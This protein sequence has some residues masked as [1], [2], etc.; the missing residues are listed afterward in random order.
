MSNF[1]LYIF[2]WNIIFNFIIYRIVIVLGKGIPMFLI[3]FL[4]LLFYVYS[5]FGASFDLVPWQYTFYYNIFIG[6][7]FTFFTFTYKRTN[8]R[9]KNVDSL[10]LK[11]NLFPLYFLL[12]VLF[13]TSYPL[14]DLKKLIIP[15]TL[16]LNKDIIYSVSPKSFG[17]DSI[18]VISG[19]LILILTPFYYLSLYG[20]RDKPFKLFLLLFFPI[21]IS[22]SF[23]GYVGRSTLVPYLFIYL[24]TL[25][26]F[27]PDLRRIM[28]VVVSV[29]MAPLIF[30]LYYYS[31][32]RLGHGYENVTFSDAITIISG[33]E[34]SFPRHY[35]D[36][37]NYSFDYKIIDYFIWLFTLPF[38]GFL[39]NN[40]VNLNVNF[41]FSSFILGIDVSS[42]DFFVLLP[43]LVNESI[44]IFGFKLF[45]INALVG[46]VV[47]GTMF[48]IVST[49]P[50]FS[51]IKSYF[52]FFIIPLAARAGFFSSI[53]LIVNGF[54]VFFI[55]IFFSKLRLYD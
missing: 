31:E 19:Y 8:F 10:F 6:V 33:Q 45:W 47:F 23:S 42:T 25:Y 9:I 15:E 27:R 54:I 41:D 37:I 7:F 20:F 26:T 18:K 44:F 16:S 46:G 52:I 36:L 11:L 3:I 43:G 48:K 32:S 55:L 51:V 4:L 24:S 12:L 34:L 53:P 38:P 14:F 28:I 50:N 5:G 17:V 2:F 21:Y 29:C 35:L 1:N 40:L 49:I 39:K 13:N 22:Y 30:F